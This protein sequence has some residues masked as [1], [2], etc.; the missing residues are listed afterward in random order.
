[1]TPGEFE[2]LKLDIAQPGLVEKIVLFD[3]RILDGRHR[4]Q[5]KLEL[6]LGFTDDDF[7][8]MEL[9]DESQA[10]ARVYSASLGRNMT[11]SQKAAAAVNLL[12][13]FEREAELRRTGSKNP[14]RPAA[15][16]D[17]QIVI[18]RDSAGKS[19]AVAGGLFGVSVRYVEMAKRLKAEAPEVF[20][21][22]FN[23]ALPVSR[24]CPP[25]APRQK[26]ERDEGRRRQPAGGIRFGE[27]L[28][29]PRRRLPEDPPHLSPQKLPLIACDPPYNIGVDYHD[30]SGGKSDKLSP[31]RY[32]KW[33]EDWLAE[34]GDSPHR[35]WF[36][37]DKHGSIL[38][39]G[40]GLRLQK[41]RPGHAELRVKWFEG[42]GENCT[43]KFNRTSRHLLYF[44]ASEKR[45]C[46]ERSAV[47]VTSLRA[48]PRSAG[49]YNDARVAKDES[50]R[51]QP[52]NFDDVW[53][54]PRV[55]DNFPE[56]MKGFPT[57]LP[58][59]LLTPIVACCTEPGDR[60]LDCFNGSG[61]TGEAC[62]RL[63]RHYSGIDKS[64]EFLR[65]SEERLRAVAAEVMKKT[66]Q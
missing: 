9:S 39:G 56:R 30:G 1:M 12:P 52:K 66:A 47:A 35:R 60:V 34:C 51:P 65:R 61:T 31:E 7:E 17:H 41:A 13:Y 28:Y 22:V 19:Y 62:V 42:W 55:A 33:C 15:P 21:Q 26:A 37:V 8:R 2:A 49:G 18:S 53:S 64:R 6:G 44:T 14:A 63:G 25:S 10:L 20:A 36:A 11:D 24:A 16:R 43:E 4:H 27:V 3:G 58:V 23:G 45:F 32:V 29:P 46:F 48:L 57:Q 5:A 59:A 38:G 54:I 50:G 40:A